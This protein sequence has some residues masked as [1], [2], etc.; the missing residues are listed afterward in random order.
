M[1][2]L[3]DIIDQEPGDE[4]ELAELGLTSKGLT[5]W[6]MMEQTFKKLLKAGVRSPFGSGAVAGANR[7][8][9]ED[10]PISSP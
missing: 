3:D 7:F 2:T 10:R 6:G 9:M 4:R 1:T 8:L 5:R